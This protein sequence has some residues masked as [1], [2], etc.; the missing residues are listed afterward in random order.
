MGKIISLIVQ[1]IAEIAIAAF[2]DSEKDTK[3]K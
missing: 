1:L 2:T 3:D